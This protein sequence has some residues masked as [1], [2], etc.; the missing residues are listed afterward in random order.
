MTRPEAST[1]SPLQTRRIPSDFAPGFLPLILVGVLLT[2]AGCAGNSRCCTRPTAVP[3]P[4]D[5]AVLEPAAN[6]WATYPSPWER[7]RRHQ[8][9]RLEQDR[10]DFQRR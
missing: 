8:E 9:K 5:R 2:F 10:A 7:E 3:D 4:Q 6:S 1:P